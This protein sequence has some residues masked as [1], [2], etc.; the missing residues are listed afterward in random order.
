[1]YTYLNKVTCS[2]HLLY[3]AGKILTAEYTGK[4]EAVNPTQCGNNLQTHHHQFSMNRLNSFSEKD[5]KYSFLLHF[6]SFLE[7]N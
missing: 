6:V 5:Y 4:D 7:A 1:M 3:S 2:V